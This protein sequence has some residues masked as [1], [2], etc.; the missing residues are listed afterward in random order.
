[1]LG[2][3]LADLGKSRLEMLWALGAE[4]MERYTADYL[5]LNDGLE[6][7]SLP[8]WDLW[9]AARLAHFASF[10]EDAEAA[11]R[12]KAQYDEFVEAALEAL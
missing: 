3:P 11:G 5:A 1:M 9:G 6:A 4:A 8:V 12:M 10:A 7:S 2:D